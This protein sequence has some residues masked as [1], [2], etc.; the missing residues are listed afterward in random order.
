MVIG[1]D[2]KE[3]EG[4]GESMAGER[5]P[6]PGGEKNLLFFFE[7]GVHGLSFVLLTYLL[8]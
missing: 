6:D 1:S 2:D 7:P 3:S 5:A 4:K 8:A